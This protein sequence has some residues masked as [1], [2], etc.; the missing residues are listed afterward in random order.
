MDM[1]SPSSSS[2]ESDNVDAGAFRLLPV[3]VEM[4]VLVVMVRVA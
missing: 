1:L 4:P 3:V 2:D